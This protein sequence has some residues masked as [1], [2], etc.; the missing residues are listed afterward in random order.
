[1]EWHRHEHIEWLQVR[2]DRC[3]RLA[4]VCCPCPLPV[5]FEV[6]DGS[7]QPS[8]KWPDDRTC[9]RFSGVVVHLHERDIVAGTPQR[10]HHGWLNRCN[11][12]SQSAHNH[13]PRRPHPAQRFG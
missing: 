4:E 7:T 9:S 2:A 10:S 13:V 12:A 5:I 11:A 1:M 8:F 6:N 3:K